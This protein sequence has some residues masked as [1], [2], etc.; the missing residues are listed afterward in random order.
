[1]ERR[2]AFIARR[3]FS[4]IVSDLKYMF[5]ATDVIATGVIVTDAIASLAMAMDIFV[6]E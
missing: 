6:S 4:Q 5:Y 1:V 2:C 3:L